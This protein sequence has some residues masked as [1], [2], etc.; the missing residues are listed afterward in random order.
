MISLLDIHIP[1]DTYIK[2]QSRHDNVAGTHRA[3][4]KLQKRQKAAI[5]IKLNT[6]LEKCRKW[7]LKS[8]ENMYESRHQDFGGQNFDFRKAEEEEAD[9]TCILSSSKINKRRTAQQTLR[10][11]TWTRFC[12]AHDTPTTTTPPPP[13]RAACC[14]CC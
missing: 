7:P 6:K 4:Q 8:R 12:T 9:Q 13:A 3:Y 10:A 11:A 14:A 2:V 1:K 5:E